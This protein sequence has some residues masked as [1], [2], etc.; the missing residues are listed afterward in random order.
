MLNQKIAKMFF[1][2]ADILEL[3]K[4]KWKPQ[5]YRKA[6]RFLESMKE[7][8]YDIYGKNGM[9]GLDEIPGIGERIAKKIEEYIRTGKMKRYET[10]KK[11]V[12][13]SYSE[14][15]NVRTLGPK[16][17]RFLNE[18]L[19]IKTIQQLKLAIKNE[20]LRS[21]KG[22]GKKSEKNISE[23]IN[24]PKK[25]GKRYPYREAYSAALPIYN[26]LKKLSITNRIDFGGS[27]RR[28]ERTIGDIDLLVVSDNP[29]KLIDEF[30]KLKQ[31]RKVLT[32]GKTKAMV[33]LKNNMQADI[34]VV[35]PE[36]YGAALQ[37]YTGNKIH[38]INLRELARKKGFKLN[39]YGLFDRKT[40]RRLSSKT[41]ND[42]YKKL[43]FKKAPKPEERK[44]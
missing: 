34:L 32:K 26:S 3:E 7:D 5:A 20:K 33:I 12:S 24:F 28:K 21:L 9:K 2:M 19:G 44:S 23:E 38:N 37:Y 36:S 10:L 14:L 29:E 39:E 30:T 31:I 42:I 27:L 43:G 4:V 17:A 41:E 35:K 22:F 15:M 13:S 25:T 40:N 16:K 8:V 11:Q 6:A 18:K 1:K